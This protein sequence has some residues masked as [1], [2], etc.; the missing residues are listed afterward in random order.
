MSTFRIL[1]V[2]ALFAV[3]AVGADGAETKRKANNIGQTTKPLS[4]IGGAPQPTALAESECQILGTVVDF[5]S[6]PT[7]K[8]CKGGNGITIC[9]DKLDL[10]P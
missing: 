10:A 7:K 4:G 9:I 1:A 2:A 6:C 3:S 5:D 8:G